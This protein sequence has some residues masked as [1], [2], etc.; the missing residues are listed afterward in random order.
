MQ[1]AIGYS[2][3]G[4]C[5][6][7]CCFFNWGGGSNGKGTI[8]NTIGLGGRPSPDDVDGVTCPFCERAIQDVG[9]IG[10]AN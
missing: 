6:E 10:A 4:D 2:V 9:G 1:R 7:E 3:T 8:M 5:R